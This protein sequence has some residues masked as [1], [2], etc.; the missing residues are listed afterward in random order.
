MGLF[1]YNGSTEIRHEY[2]IA[3]HQTIV[4][5]YSFMLNFKVG[6]KLSMDRYLLVFVDLITYSYY[7]VDYMGVVWFNDDG[8]YENNISPAAA[9][10]ITV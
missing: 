3:S 8:E 1:Y 5:N 10:H 4:C 9:N 7:T 2:I 6:L